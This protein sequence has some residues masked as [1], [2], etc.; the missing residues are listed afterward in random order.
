MKRPL[1]PFWRRR[2]LPAALGL[3]ALNLVAFVAWTVPRGY[4]HR[5]ALA[6]AAAIREEAA[7]LKHRVEQAVEREGAVRANRADLET[8]YE[9]HASSGE[10][11]LLETVAAVEAMVREPGLKPGARGIARED[12]EG[13]R[14]QRVSLSLP[15]EGSY[16]QLVRF[17]REVETSRRF[18]TVE[19]ISLS[20]QREVGAALAVELSTY[21]RLPPGAQKKRGRRAR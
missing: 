14:L 11:E 21:L 17:L 15:V 3:C 9:K 5:T 7:R 13:T 19:G 18:L 1:R 8:F 20:A 10:G 16:S 2:L 4:R 6:R 12:I